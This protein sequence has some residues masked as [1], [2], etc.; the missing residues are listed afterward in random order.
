MKEN[1]SVSSAAV[2]V[3]GSKKVRYQ[4]NKGVYQQFCHGVFVPVDAKRTTVVRARALQMRF[5]KAA[6]GGFA[7]LNY[8]GLPYFDDVEV[9]TIY[10]SASQRRREGNMQV[11]R[12]KGLR[13]WQGLD[14]DFPELRV[15]SKERALV[16]SLAA[17]RSG[18]VTWP[19][20]SVPELA[21][22][23]VRAIQVVD[24]ARCYLRI[25]ENLLRRA[26]TSR[27]DRLWLNKAVAHSDGG[28]HSPQ[29][30]L[31][32]LQIADVTPGIRSQIV[33]EEE[34]Y[35]GAH[36][37]ITCADLGWEEW[38]VAAYYDGKQHFIEA[39][40]ARD[41]RISQWLH[42]HGWADIRVSH[43]MLWDGAALRRQVARTL[44]QQGRPGEIPA[45]PKNPWDE[46]WRA[47]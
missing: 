45:Q 4:A 38:K 36:R 17:I 1:K 29:E 27:V 42:E 47:A 24:A 16:D 19:V 21:P 6:I 8:W 31:L 20:P 44:K 7:A 25:G 34:S 11:I 33:F 40:R 22:E 14:P 26:A 10:A 12:A 37:K 18:R 35:Y 13:S 2:P 9:D 43:A 23:L 3:R 28:A 32:R 30:T 15:V 46:P 41:L 5:P 39:D